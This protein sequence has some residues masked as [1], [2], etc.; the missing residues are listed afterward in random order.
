MTRFK[1]AGKRIGPKHILWA[2]IAMLCIVLLIAAYQTGPVEEPLDAFP[3]TAG[4]VT[5]PI[6]AGE[7]VSQLF[8][9]EKPLL[10]LSF[11]VATYQETIQEGFLRVNIVSDG[12]GETVFTRDIPASELGDI[13]VVH[14]QPHLPA[15]TYNVYFTPEGIEADKPIG[16]YTIHEPS[17]LAGYIQYD[18]EYEDS[19]YLGRLYNP[20]SGGAQAAFLRI[21]LLILGTVAAA[22]LICGFLKAR[23]AKPDTLRPILPAVIGYL[24][25]LCAAAV[26]YVRFGVMVKSESFFFMRDSRLLFYVTALFLMGGIFCLLK[27]YSEAILVFLFSVSMVLLFTDTAYSAV[28]EIAHAD[29]IVRLADT[30]AFPNVYDNYEAV[31]GPVSYYLSALLVGWLP[32]SYMYL[33][34][35]T[36][37]ALQMLLNA[38]VI[39]KTLQ[40]IRN[41]FP[42]EYSDR[43]TH[44][45]WLLFSVNPM[46]LIRF[47]RVSNEPLVCLFSSLAICG[48]TKLILH[49]YNKY[50]LGRCTVLC[51]L[52]FLTKSTSFVLFGLVFLVCAYHKK[53]KAF[54]VQLALYI[55]IPLPWFISN[56]MTYGALTAM[57]GHLECVLPI[58]NPGM[59]PPDVWRDL[60]Q[61]F[62]HYFL[63]PE[64]G[65][66]YDV[67]QFEHFANA[68]LLIFLESAILF[69]TGYLVR[70]VKSR[71]QFS[72]SVSEKEDFLFMTYAAL[73]AVSYAVHIIQSC[74]TLNLSTGNNRYAVM[75]NSAFC[76]LLLLGTARVTK[77][78]KTLL[79]F[80]L[81]GFFSLVIL[82]LICGYTEVILTT[83]V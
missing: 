47:G 7:T 73:P 69:G 74:M 53:W 16:L 80:Y 8:V 24:C 44:I 9:A 76:G 32:E 17:S 82:A 43:L 14:I 34:A 30:F 3:R 29:I 75:L 61:Y 4:G 13:R 31:Q 58:V 12:T 39:R 49:G 56:Y 46:I 18:D 78:H 52:A 62:F 28:D 5:E 11:Q 65:S 77:K 20:M 64:A 15:G 51:A 59:A 81:T 72:H 38:L 79:A 10:D 19:L 2:V 26:L 71:L 55:M 57:K 42:G 33:G 60:Q 70:F 25:F 22:L 67:P 50:A 1:K 45:I 41:A 40:E 6:M 36:V 27:D 54:F 37:G 23:K 35:R 48:A 21:E 66:W 83:P 68:L 63:V